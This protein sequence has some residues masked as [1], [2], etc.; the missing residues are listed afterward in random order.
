MKSRGY[1]FLRTDKSEAGVYMYWKEGRSGKCVTVRV[2]GGRYQSL[3]YAPASN[4]QTAQSTPKPS[5]PSAGTPVAK[6]QDL[7]GA[8]AGQAENTLKQRGYQFL[9]SSQEGDSIYSYWRETKTSH[10]VTIRMEQGR[11]Q[12]IVYADPLDCQ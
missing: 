9:K 6:L 1:Q 5:H 4:C 7:V 11:Y 12:S 10:C 3:V 8:R 2:E